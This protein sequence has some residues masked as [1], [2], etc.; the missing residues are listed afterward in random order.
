MILPNLLK[1]IRY[2]KALSTE[3]EI[4]NSILQKAITLD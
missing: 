2:I 1:I 4:I 3:E